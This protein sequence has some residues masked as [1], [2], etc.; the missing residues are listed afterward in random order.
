MER[1]KWRRR[2]AKPPSPE[3]VAWYARTLAEVF[4][5]G[6][7]DAVRG[8]FVDPSVAD[9]AWDCLLALTDPVSHEAIR[10]VWLEAPDGK[11]KELVRDRLP[12]DVRQR[13][14]T[15]FLLGD[16]EGYTTVDP[17][18]ALLESAR[19]EGDPALRVQLA[20]AARRG[21]RLGWAY[22][23][24]AVPERLLPEEWEALIELLRDGNRQQY[25]WQLLDRARLHWSARCLVELADW[26]QADQTLVR[27]ATDYLNQSAAPFELLARL[28]RPD[29]VGE[30]KVTS[31]GSTLISTRP[32]TRLWRLPAEP[33]PADASPIESRVLSE[34]GYRSAISPDGSLLA[35]ASWGRWSSRFWRRSEADPLFRRARTFTENMPAANPTVALSPDGTLAAIGRRGEV[36]IRRLPTGRTVAHLPLKSTGITDVR[37]LLIPPAGDTVV[38]QGRTKLD[39]WRAII[40]Q[41]PSG[42]PIANLAVRANAQSPP[43]VTPDG[44]YLAVV[45]SDGLALWR[46]PGYTRLETPRGPSPSTSRT[47]AAVTPDSRLLISSGRHQVDLFELPSGRRL[48]P[49]ELTDATLLPT[50]SGALLIGTSPDGS[51]AVLRYRPSPQ[52]SLASLLTH[53]KPS[54]D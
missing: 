11:L 18:G 39:E 46:L 38:V 52:T 15:L 9:M 16:F 53:P 23:V 21:K 20:I 34:T 22:R 54:R 2:N 43:V 6:S 25:L 29:D 8:M 4:V 35:V 30:F 45:E 33:Q 26:P 40:A 28:H 41:L 14:V 24:A 27:L 7:G 13:A 1:P 50:A 5:A 19:A 49:L 32:S 37:T 3:R 10:H 47:N 48:D 31:D 42:A 17:S 51:I 44:Q 12:A 36:R